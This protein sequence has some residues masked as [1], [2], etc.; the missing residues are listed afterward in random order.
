MDPKL[1]PYLPL[2]FQNVCVTPSD[3]NE[4]CPILMA[5]ASVHKHVTEFGVRYGTSTVAFLA[6]KPTKLVSYDMHRQIEV[7]AFKKMAP[8]T[9]FVFIEADTL[10]VDIEETDLLFIDTLHTAKQLSAELFRHAG[11]VRRTIVMHDTETFGYLGEDGSAGGLKMA[12]NGFLASSGDWATA[13][14]FTNNN[15][16]TVLLRKGMPNALK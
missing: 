8:E 5:L 7:D 13:R 3:I 4:H 9:E 12:L 11:K 1:P 14:H 16:L 6:G 15:G 10:S 2:Q